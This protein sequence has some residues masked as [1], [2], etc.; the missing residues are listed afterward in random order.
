MNHLVQTLVEPRRQAILKLIWEQE[1]TAGDIASEFDVS[2]SAVS[3]HLARLREVGAVS[4]RRDGRRRYYR[5]RPDTMGPIAGF[6]E[7]LWQTG[8]DRLR[9]LAE[10]EA[11]KHS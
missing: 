11:E 5:A 10:A 9:D 8:L 4:V 6:L 1:R 7:S 3:Q 2:F